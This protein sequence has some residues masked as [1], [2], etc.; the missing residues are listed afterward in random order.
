MLIM[1]SIGQ[2]LVPHPLRMMKSTSMRIVIR[3]TTVPL[4]VPNKRLG[5][6]LLAQLCALKIFLITILQS[7]V[8]P[9]RPR[10]A[11]MVESVNRFGSTELR[12]I[13]LAIPDSEAVPPT[14]R[15][16]SLAADSDDLDHGVAKAPSPTPTIPAHTSSTHAI[17]VDA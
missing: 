15:H 11:Y 1:A 3:A 16:N 5:P 6:P 7:F 9:R 13:R 14:T 2:P 4:H 8:L 10:T 17:P 12:S